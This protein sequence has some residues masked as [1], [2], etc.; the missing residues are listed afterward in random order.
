MFLDLTATYDTIW[1]RG[2]T[3]KLLPNRHMVHMIMELVYNRSFTLTTGS[4]QR[5]RLRCLKNGVPQGSVLA[6]LL[7]NI[8]THDLPNT[9]S[10]EYA[11]ADDLA[12]VHPARKWETL[13]GDFEPGHVY[14]IGI[15][16][17][18]EIEAQRNQNSVGSF[19]FEQQG[20]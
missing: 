6:P 14:F 10:V 17:E 16:P 9:V 19:P 8:Y 15:P 11:Y 2:L 3:G 7:L 20:S 1:H 12:I 18:M 5:S 13:E 4:G